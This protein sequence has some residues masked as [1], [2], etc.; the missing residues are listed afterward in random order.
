MARDIREFQRHQ[1]LMS[2]NVRGEKLAAFY[3]DL[4]DTPIPQ[5][6]TQLLAELEQ[7]AKERQC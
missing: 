4:L 3:K 7:T 2:L 1:D 5:R 6:F